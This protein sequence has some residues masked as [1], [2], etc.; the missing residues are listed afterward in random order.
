[1]T[2]IIATALTKGGVGKTTT[3]VNLAHALARLE[4]KVLLVDLDTQGQA[5][6]SLTGEP[7]K[8]GLADYLTDK[9]SIDQALFPVR[10]NLFLLAGGRSIAALETEISRKAIGGERV[11][12]KGIEPHEDAFD[13]VILDVPPGFGSILINALFYA[14]EL[15]IPASLQVLSLQ[16]L[17][18]FNYHLE[19]VREYNPDIKISYILPTFQDRRTLQSSEVLEQLK[20]V[21]GARVCDPVNNSVRL[22][23]APGHRKTIWEYAPES[24]GAHDYAKL[25]EKVISDE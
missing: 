4:R 2:R 3:A 13:Y 15:L 20:K 6:A 23:E 12:K 18:E 17:V 25:V 9:C 8:Y 1:M 21:Y 16:S 14:K 11:L 22:S 24:T 10:D 5:G 19:T 7:V